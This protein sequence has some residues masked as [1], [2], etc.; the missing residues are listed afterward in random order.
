MTMNL[1]ANRDRYHDRGRDSDR[2]RDNDRGRD[3]DRG[4]EGFL[5]EI[6]DIY[7]TEITGLQ[8]IINSDIVQA[9]GKDDRGKDGKDGRERDRDRNFGEDQD[10]AGDAADIYNT[11]IVA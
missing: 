4:F 10:L 9:R 3:F 11:D 5:D 1:N 8:P 7:N 2:G 6:S